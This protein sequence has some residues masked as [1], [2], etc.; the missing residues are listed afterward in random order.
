MGTNPYQNF[1]GVDTGQTGTL[2]R[3]TGESRYPGD[4]FHGFRLS[5]ER[6]QIAESLNWPYVRKKF[7]F[8]LGVENS[9]F[10]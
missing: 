7:P 4:S 9:P 3:H 5:P 8:A 2:L 6:R 1:E 10:A